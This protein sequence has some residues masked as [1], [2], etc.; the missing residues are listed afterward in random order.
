MSST[1]EFVPPM[2]VPAARASGAVLSLLRARGDVL[3]AFPAEAY[4]RQIIPLSLPGRRIFI[5]NH[6]DLVRQVFVSEHETYQRKSRF[7][8][9]AL[10]P[11]VG[12][13]LFINHGPV[14]AERREVIAP[15]LHP[16]RIG[17]FHATFLQVA[18]EL[19]ETLDRMAP[20]PV[21]FSAVF[22]TATARVMMLALFGP[23]V[24]REDAAELAKAFAA[25][26]QAADNVDIRT[27]LNLPAW[28]GGRQGYR[29]RGRAEALRGLIRRNLA[30]VTDPPP[31]LRTMQEARRADGSAVMDGDALVNEVAM[32]L[33]AGSETSA[34]ALTWTTYL[35]AAHPP[36]LRTLMEEYAR[37]SP[38]RPPS[39]EDIAEM[40]VTRAVAQEALRLYPP[41]AILSR[42]ALAEDRLRSWAVKPGNMV[43]AVPWLLHRHAMWWH[44]PHAFLPERFF[45]ENA[46][47]QPKFTY[48]PF[49]IGPRVCAGAAFALSEMAVFLAVLLRR[50]IPVVPSGWAPV[51]HCR[52]T[53][54][55]RDGMPLMLQRR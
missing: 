3:S 52:L 39:A 49:G 9:Q 29:A 53:L 24:P 4:R 21:D 10:E 27:L 18:E 25:Y 36:T 42:Q 50:F 22:A 44:A 47:R 13:S 6:P 37:L 33:L 8:E 15:P 2:P 17:A 23:S 32:M 38:G 5:V 41:V 43:M 28:M 31:L 19:V 7:M 20:G 14:W 1:A 34:N 26:Q 40:M 45:P 35:L 55:P 48:I 54:R 12:D 30:A 46:R 51:P 16:A 11:V